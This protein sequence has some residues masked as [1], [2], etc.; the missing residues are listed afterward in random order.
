VSKYHDDR[1]TATDPG[2]VRLARDRLALWPRRQSF[3]QMIGR[4]IH[5]DKHAERIAE[6]LWL[7]DSRAATVV[8]PSPLL[9]AAY[10]DELDCVAILAFPQEFQR[11][12]NLRT[13]SRL[14]TVNTYF[15]LPD[16]ASDLSLGPGNM[17]RYGNFYPLIA[18]F[19]SEDVDRI[20][21]RK[22]E[23]PESEWSRC[24]EL[25]RTKIGLR[26]CVPRDGSP[27]SSF[28]PTATE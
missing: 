12:F 6:H 24:A 21:A 5:G 22:A 26:T 27:F 2:G 10:S 11:R 4:W 23:I 3:A 19:L 8:S 15:Y 18:E 28:Q 17:N 9:V 1:T 25:G 14:L 16:V 7:G 20:A 13:R